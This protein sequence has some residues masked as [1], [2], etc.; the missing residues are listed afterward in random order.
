VV[1]AEPISETKP[2]RG[3]LLG[4]VAAGLLLRLFWML[5]ASPVPVSDYGKFRELA[6][7]LFL[8]H[9]F[10]WPE[11]T[12]YRFPAYPAFLAAAMHVSTSD[13]WMR[14]VDVV[15]STALIPAAYVL[16]RRLANGD[17]RY[18]IAAAWVTA[19]NPGFV[20]WAPILA[21][22]HPFALLVFV[23]LALLVR[24]GGAQAPALLGSGVCLALAS[25]TRGEGLFQ[26]PTFLLTA[27][28]VSPRKRLSIRMRQIA[29]MLVPVVLIVGG[30]VARNRAEIGPG[31]GVST[32]GGVNFYMGHGQAQYGYQADTG[33][34]FENLSEVEAQKRAYRMSFDALKRDPLRFP[35]D[36]V[37]GTWEQYRPGAYAVSWSARLPRVNNVYPEKNIPGRRFFSWLQVLGDAA[38]CLRARVSLFL[39]RRMTLAVWLVP[40]SLAF[41]S[42]VC[43]AVVFN[44]NSRY[45]YL[46][47]A[48]FCLLAANA[49]VALRHRSTR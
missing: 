39:T 29:V 22:E 8:H 5:Y 41:W 10:G 43:Y 47:E 37:V 38:R 28:L 14:F 25:L 24:P 9:Q 16:A 42:W 32:S 40:V 7:D 33:T 45:R 27:W 49:L 23:G 1:A 6:Y 31:A 30:W 35:K 12:A 3:W 13:G 4:A 18:G 20:F 11:P 17:R 48:A 21:S 2:R 44:A 26:V 36:V 46:G 34:P 15:L 19:L